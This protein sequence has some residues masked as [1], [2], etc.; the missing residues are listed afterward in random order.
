M[1]SALQVSLSKG[2]DGKMLKSSAVDCFVFVFPGLPAG[3]SDKG[4]SGDGRNGGV[5]LVV[6]RDAFEPLQVHNAEHCQSQADPKECQANIE[7]P[8]GK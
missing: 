3:R 7:P 6:V 5:L 1:T 2:S 8:A 4:C